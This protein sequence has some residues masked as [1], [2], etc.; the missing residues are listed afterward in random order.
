MDT[1]TGEIR[2]LTAGALPS[3]D[4]VPFDQAT[5]DMLLKMHEEFRPAAL[6][7]LCRKHPLGRLPG[8]SEG[9]VRKL[10]NAGKRARRARR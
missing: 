4:E 2:P 3:N 5:A 8:M 9:D 10:R 7:A 6:L 1:R